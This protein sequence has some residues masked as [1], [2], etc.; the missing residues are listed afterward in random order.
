MILRI[1]TYLSHIFI[2]FTSLSLFA[3]LY[4]GMF[5]PATTSLLSSNYENSSITSSKI[6]F[7]YS[8]SYRSF[9]YNYG[10]NPIE[11]YRIYL[12]PLNYYNDTIYI[13]LD[14]RWISSN[15]IPPHTVFALSVGDDTL[16]KVNS[17]IFFT[18]GG[19]IRINV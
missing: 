14:N 4:A 18:D 10:D 16:S 3:I 5:L 8:N 17:V 7:L 12:D 15:V 6:S 9:F 2:F 19:V 11:I 1:S 13:I